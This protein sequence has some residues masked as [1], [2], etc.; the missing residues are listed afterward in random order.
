MDETDVS[1]IKV[2]DSAVIQI[3]AFTD[4]TFVG[5]VV[6]ISNSSVAGATAGGTAATDQAIDYEVRGRS[7][8]IRPSILVRTSRPRPRSSRIR[9]SRA[10]DSDHCAHRA[11][12]R[13]RSRPSDSAMS[14]GRATTPA[15]RSASA[16]VEGV[17]VVGT[18]NKVTFRPVK[19][20]IAGERHFEVLDGHLRPARTSWPERIR[21]FASLRMARWC[22]LHRPPQTP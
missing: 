17:F 19:V 18:D 22:E 15:G 5:R 13:E 2:G 11:G 7:S 21:P 4:T 3:D 12:E 9:A 8:S 6:E 20:G 10:V 1:R 14:V 16:D